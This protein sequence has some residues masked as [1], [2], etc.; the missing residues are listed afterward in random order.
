MDFHLPKREIFS[1]K[2]PRYPNIWFYVNQILVEE[3]LEAVYLVISNLIKYCNIKN[4]FSEN[5]R[6]RHIL[7][8]ENEGSD[9][10]GRCRGLQPYTDLSHPSFSHDHQIHVRY[11]FRSLMQHHSERVR[12]NFNNEAILFYRLA[13]SAHYEISTENQNH[14]FLEF[15]PIC[16]RTGVYDKEL[17]RDDLDKEICREVHDPL[18]VEILLKNTI[19]GSKIYNHRGEE[20]TFVDRLRNDCDL[21]TYLLDPTDPEMNTPKIGHVLI[22][23]IYYNRDVLLK[24]IKVN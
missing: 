16:G 2:M 21:E 9:A 1:K 12:L 6:L 8:N 13:L 15:C 3:Y 11:Y 17:D 7:F 14:P 22:K 18:G 10:E 23:K 24:N 5:Y 20:I 4:N 19:R